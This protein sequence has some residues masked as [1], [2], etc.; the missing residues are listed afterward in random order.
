[1]LSMTAAPKTLSKELHIAARLSFKA[2]PFNPR[3]HA[4]D[5]DIDMENN[6]K[7]E[8]F[9]LLEL[10]PLFVMATAF[11]MEF[12]ENTYDGSNTFSVF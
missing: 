7:S 12:Q 2:S 1:M 10:M 5:K 4:V 3:M 11:V 9:G 8:E 6:S